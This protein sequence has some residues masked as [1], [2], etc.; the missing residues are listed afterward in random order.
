VSTDAG[1][2]RGLRDRPL[3]K[4]A[5][6]LGVLAVALVVA[7]GCAG[8]GSEI[9]KEDAIEIARREV[10]YE[11]DRTQVRLVRRGF[12][13]RPFWAVSLSLLD[14]RGNFERVT[15]VVVD[16]RTRRIEEIRES[17]Q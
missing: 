12:Q 6:L 2:K 5:L 13:S 16:A 10:D 9:P 15:V 17:T 7:R 3:G 4:I 11:P 8:A 1:T 14:E